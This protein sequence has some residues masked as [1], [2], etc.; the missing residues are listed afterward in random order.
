MKALY[1]LKYILSRGSEIF[2]IAT[3]LLYAVSAAVSGGIDGLVPTLASI[4]MFLAMSMVIAAGNLILRQAKVT[5][6]AKLAL[7]AL[8][9]AVAYYLIFVVCGGH[10]ANGSMT[11]AAMTV[12]IVCYAVFAVIWL[13]VNRSKGKRENASKSYSS[14]FD[15]KD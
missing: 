7:H 14:M 6:G 5:K 9:L 10:A 8:T 2:T 3:V 11:L 15:D 4:L 1:A 12:F 13:I